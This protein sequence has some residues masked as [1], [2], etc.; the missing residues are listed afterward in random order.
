MFKSC[1]VQYGLQPVVALPINKAQGLPGPLG[2][3]AIGAF[4]QS[5]A[6]VWKKLIKI[7]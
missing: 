4:I 7:E 1:Q 2:P 5:E 3:Q 6:G